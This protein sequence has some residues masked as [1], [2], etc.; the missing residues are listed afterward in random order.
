MAPTQVADGYEW[1][2]PKASTTSNGGSGSEW[3]RY[4]TRSVVLTPEDQLDEGPC[5]FTEGTYADS[6]PCG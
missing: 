5:S 3:V 4:G 2:Q 6:R 1:L